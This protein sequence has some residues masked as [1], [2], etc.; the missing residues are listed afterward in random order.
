MG[1]QTRVGNKHHL[2]LDIDSR[3]EV[4]CLYGALSEGARKDPRWP[5]CRGRLL[6]VILDRYGIRWM[7]NPHPGFLNGRQSKGPRESSPPRRLPET[8]HAESRF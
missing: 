7:V 1:Q 5:T 2:C 8:E 6:D 4:D 3:K